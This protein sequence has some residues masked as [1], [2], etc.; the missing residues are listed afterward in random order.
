MQTLFISQDLL[1]L[2]EEG[3]KMYHHHYHQTRRRRT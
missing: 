2:T 1:D 3:D